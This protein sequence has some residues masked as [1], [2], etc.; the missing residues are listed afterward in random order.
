MNV[1]SAPYPS[2]FWPLTALILWLFCACSNVGVVGRVCPK[3]VCDEPKAGRDQEPQQQGG[4]GPSPEAAT[5]QATDPLTD[6]HAQGPSDAC[7][8][9]ATTLQRKRLDIYLLLDDSGS[10]VPWWEDT[11][12]ALQAFFKDEGSADIAVGLKLFGTSC[13]AGTYEQPQVAIEVLPSNA[14]A[15]EN[16]IPVL[17]TEGAATLPALQGAVQHAQTW[18]AQH[19]DSDVLV[20]LLTAGF[21]VEC[22]S[23]L[24]KV[25]QLAR[26]ARELDPPVTTEVVVLGFTGAVA[27]FSQSGSAALLK[28]VSQTTAIEILNA[29]K[30]VRQE[31]RSCSFQLPL[32]MH[33]DVAG[34]NSTVVH[35]HSDGARAVIP[36]VPD[37]AGCDPVQAGWFF[38]DASGSAITLCPRSCAELGS[39]PL[40]VLT[41]CARATTQSFRSGL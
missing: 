9:S 30:A 7:S 23:T 19:P 38:A 33:G 6:A 25:A 41:G 21:P 5:G 17:P 10:M 22:E 20:L 12:S 31:A 32:Q 26:T 34:A 4:H 11:R 35:E 14:G 37:A 28:V 39:D 2:R 3:S 29:L 36:A 18:S 27:V 16:A 15:L 1:S 24:E 8:P 13:E 40:N